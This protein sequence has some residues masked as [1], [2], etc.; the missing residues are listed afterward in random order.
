[1]FAKTALAAAVFLGLSLQVSAHAGI[2]PALGVTGTFIRANVQR[3]SAAAP[4]G[5]INIAANINNSTAIP[6]NPDG[7]FG[8]TITDFNAGLDGSREIA[9]VSVDPTATG[10]DFSTGPTVL[11][12]GD[13]V[14][15]VVGS[16]PL[17]VQLPTG[18]VCTG[19]L[20]GDLCL[21]SFVTAGNFGNCVVVQQ[22]SD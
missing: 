4:C 15:T 1:M 22:T 2:T 7:T 14:P 13:R 21:V 12:N 6:V 18:T 5:T 19:G 9:S 11:T 17:V 16:Q 10:T 8:A 3:P 20:S